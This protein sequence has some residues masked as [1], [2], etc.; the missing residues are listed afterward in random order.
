MKKVFLILLICLFIHFIFVYI[1]L[2]NNKDTWELKTFGKVYKLT[3][4]DIK[5]FERV[6]KEFGVTDALKAIND[7]GEFKD[8]KALL[9]KEGLGRDQAYFDWIKSKGL[10]EYIHPENI[11]ELK[12][13]I[14]DP[15]NYKLGPKSRE[16]VNSALNIDPED[17]ANFNK[18]Y[19]ANVKDAVEWMIDNHKSFIQKS[20][21]TNIENKMKMIQDAINK[22]YGGKGS[23]DYAMRGGWGD[24]KL[25]SIDDDE[26]VQASKNYL[27]DL[28]KS[29][30]DKVNKSNLLAVL[31]SI[32]KPLLEKV[33]T[34]A[35]IG[36][37]VG[38]FTEAGEGRNADQLMKYFP[39]VA[40]VLGSNVGP[41][42]VNSMNY[43]NNR[44]MAF[45]NKY[46]NIHGIDNSNRLMI[47]NTKI[48]P[49]T[50]E[51]I[52]DKDPVFS[53]LWIPDDDYQ[54]RLNKNKADEVRMKKF[55]EY[56]DKLS[57]ETKE[58]ITKYYK[59]KSVDEHEIKR[60]A[61]LNFINLFKS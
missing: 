47:R 13:Y 36:Q 50:G 58:K 18:T 22:S 46:P 30:S 56:W 3:M 23:I 40:T 28:M 53:G 54:S 26:T 42:F 15:E 12:P 37:V 38:F 31:Q 60:E 10:D 39:E 7:F 35:P 1:Y 61:M 34:E 29:T 52:D 5:E 44:N 19:K 33:L 25:F 51:L 8:E 48:D 55:N 14:L 57:D 21:K 27:S 2:I 4:K 32:D 6:S 20:N 9:E 41:S 17:L 24:L 59:N 45:Y 43:Y 49:N 11:K 16:W